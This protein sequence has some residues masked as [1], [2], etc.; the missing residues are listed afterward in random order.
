MEGFHLSQ[1]QI[2]TLVEGGASLSPGME[3]GNQLG[4][5]MRLSNSESYVACLL[6]LFSP[7]YKQQ[8][9]LVS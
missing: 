8:S 3:P 4:Q 7:L 1:Y 2:A 6:Y 5:T 9:N